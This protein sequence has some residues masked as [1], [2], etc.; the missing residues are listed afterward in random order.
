MGASCKVARPLFFISKEGGSLKM[1]KAAIF[2]KAKS[3]LGGFSLVEI[4]TVIGIIAL[5][6]SIA[7]PGWIKARTSSRREVCQENLT[8][9]VET[10]AP[11]PRDG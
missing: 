1:V 7:V 6:I 10:L 5:I 9:I 4:M 8:K 3:Q 11:Y 2:P